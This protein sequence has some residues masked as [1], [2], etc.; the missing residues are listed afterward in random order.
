M[1]IDYHGYYCQDWLGFAWT[2]HRLIWSQ[3][4]VSQ[5]C[6]RV[7]RKSFF[8]HHFCILLVSLFRNASLKIF[9]VRKFWYAN[10]VRLYV[11]QGDSNGVYAALSHTTDSV[12]WMFVNDLSCSS[13]QSW[14]ILSVFFCDTFG[15]SSLT[16]AVIQNY[17]HN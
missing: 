14:V 3:G 5:I 4:N 2:F 8:R 10:L 15:K 6:S 12:N 7:S 1:F 11:T 17:K 13:N 9:L 16:L